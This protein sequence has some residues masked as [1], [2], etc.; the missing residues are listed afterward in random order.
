ML[1]VRIEVLAMD[2]VKSRGAATLCSNV[3]YREVLLKRHDTRVK[4][5]QTRNNL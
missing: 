3:F 1:C 5:C 2:L 4:V